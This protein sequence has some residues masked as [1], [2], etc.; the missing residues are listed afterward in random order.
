MGAGGLAGAALKKDTVLVKTLLRCLAGLILTAALFS[1]P[2]P[3]AADDTAP[4]SDRTDAL[5]NGAW[6]FHRGDAP[7]AQSV[8]FVENRSWHAIHAIPHTWNNGD[9]QDGGA[10]YYRGT[11]WYRTFVG[12]PAARGKRYFLQFDGANLTTDVWVNGVYLG[13]HVGGFSRFRFDA[14]QAVAPG[15]QNLVAVRVS[16]AAQDVPPISADFTF[17]GGLYRPVHLLT[18]DAAHVQM[19]DYGSSGVYLTPTYD[20]ATGV[21]TVSALVKVRND[22]AISRPLLVRVNLFDPGAGNAIVGTITASSPLVAGG[23][24]WDAAG[25]AAIPRPHLWNGKRD[26]FLY[27]AEVEV[28]DTS[29]PRS[30]LADGLA[31]TFGL[32]SFRVDPRVGF[33]LNGASYP[34][35]GVNKHQDRLDKGWAVSDADSDEDFRLLDEIGAT[36][37]RLCHY[38]HSEHEYDLADRYGLVTWAEIPVV[39]QVSTSKDTT[40]FDRNA[41]QQL[42]ELIRQNY[43]HPAIC[44]WS[45]SNEVTA[46]KSRPLPLLTV[47]NG[48]AHAEDPTRLTTLAALS[49]AADGPVGALT[50]VLGVNQYY[51]WYYGDAQGRGSLS[52]WAKAY[53][54]YHPNRPFALSEYGAGASIFWHSD[55]PVKGDHTEEYQNLYHEA[56]W[57][58]LKDAPYIWGTFVWNMFDFAVDGRNEGDTAGRND[59]GLVTYDRQTKKDAFFWYK[60]NWSA[61]PFVYITDHTYTTRNTPT[62]D[63]KVYANTRYVSLKVNGVGLRAQSSRDHIFLWKSVPLAPGA[64]VL[65]AFGGDNVADTAITD[66]VTWARTPDIY[67]NAG[68]RLPYTDADGKTWEVDRYLTGGTRASA[69]TAIAGTS[70]QAEY[71]TYRYGTFTCTLPVQPGRYLLRLKF[72]E[73]FWKARGKRVFSVTADGKALLTHYDVFAEV[74]ANR[75]VEKTFTLTIRPKQQS[76]TLKFNPSV[77]QA[78]VCAISAVPIK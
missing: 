33:V 20:A 22:G 76:L 54:K 26:P 48:L 35:H 14:T 29:G 27:R 7:G 1:C 11:G 46:G 28:W 60:A 74:G 25:S 41:Q 66:T 38:A 59:K 71:R 42:I 65:Q 53:H 56:H 57:L 47:L 55:H 61:S 17:F 51:G 32:R 64:N 75:A 43:N 37:L 21:W 15:A 23:A 67:V 62:A 12:V 18:L 9:G 30:V 50:D 5:I 45:I 13:R 4:P 8:K 19:L 70:D 36:A 77:D 72:D 73:P 16:N 69:A 52:P 31:Q 49:G 40:A 44:F 24:E 68:G 3:C 63:V 2:N 78:M 10:N 39:N 58:F 6:H 34:L